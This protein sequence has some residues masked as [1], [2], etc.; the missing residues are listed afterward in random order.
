MR[1]MA[2]SICLIVLYQTSM[3]NKFDFLFLTTLKDIWISHNILPA[4][5]LLI[6]E[7]LLSIYRWK[8]LAEHNMNIMLLLTKRVAK[9]YLCWHSRR[10]EERNRPFQ[11]KMLCNLRC[12]K[13][14]LR[15]LFD[16]LATVQ[17]QYEPRF[18]TALVMWHL[19]FFNGR[20][21]L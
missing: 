17:Q 21:V 15:L 13:A 6:V 5:S 18:K 16:K 3:R 10:L 8:A 9:K 19:Y 11:N 14:R 20:L 12:V 4:I 1:D 2:H 7:S